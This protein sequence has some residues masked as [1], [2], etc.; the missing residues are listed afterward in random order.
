[1]TT[2]P[3]LRRLLLLTALLTLPALG[4]IPGLP[5]LGSGSSTCDPSRSSCAPTQ[6]PIFGDIGGGGGGGAGGG[7]CKPNAGGNPCD[8]SGPASQGSTGGPNLGAGNPINVT[9][10]N[11]YQMEVDMPALPGELGLELVRHYNSAHARVLGALGAGWRLSYETELYEVGNTVQ[12]LQADGSRIIF[13]IDPANPN[14]CASGDP[15]QGHIAIDERRSANGQQRKRYTW[16]WSHGPHAGRSLHFNAQGKL[17]RI[18]AASGATLTLQRSPNGQ[19]AQVTDPQGRSLIFSYPDKATIAQAQTSEQPALFAGV[20]AITTPLG[21]FTYQHGTQKSDAANLLGVT[22]PDQTQRHYHYEDKRWP[23]RLSGI[24]MEG[25]DSSGQRTKERLSTYRYDE[26]GRGILSTKGAP[27]EGTPGQEQVTLQYLAPTLPAKEGRTLLTNSLGQHTLYRQRIIAGQYRLVEARGAGCAQCAPVNIRYH[28]D[29]QGRLIA[30]D[31]L[32]P[33]IIEPNQEPP[34]AK[35]LHSTRIQ[36]DSPRRHRPART[37]ASL[38]RRPSLARQ[39][40]P[41]HPPQR[42][43][44]A[45]TTTDPA[46]Q[47]SRADHRADAPGL[48]PHRRRRAAAADRHRAHHPVPV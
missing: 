5:D 29:D 40:H 38:L 12:V 39:T 26:R 10:G 1:M 36:L 25:T 17:E 43:C 8:S 32:A 19:L 47:R 2:A 4:Q 23:Y 33:T 28:Y 31:S 15:T 7:S 41:H 6:P 30:Q 42:R 44:R 16:H 27:P 22:S 34:P 11:K 35:T 37:R 48:E 18:S 46:L 45:A 21:R 13:A 9:N 24:S 3:H 20:Q 14:H